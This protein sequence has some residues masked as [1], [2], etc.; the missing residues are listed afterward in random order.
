MARPTKPR[1]VRHLPT[2]TEFRPSKRVRQSILQL[3]IDE[4]EALY[5]KDVAKLTQEECAKMMGVSRQTVQM[6]LESAHYKVALA[7]TGGYTLQISGGEVVLHH[8]LFECKDCGHTREVAANEKDTTCPK[9]HSANTHCVI[10]D[11]CKLH[12]Q[13]HVD[14]EA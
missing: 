5:L 13:R 4:W 10:D 2:V 9:C 6:I 12:C 8:C 7:I 14:I 1:R 11:F 3:G